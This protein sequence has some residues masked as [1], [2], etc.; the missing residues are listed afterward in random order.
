MSDK[1]QSGS[2]AVCVALLVVLIALALLR[3]RYGWDTPITDSHAWRQTQTAISAYYMVGQDFKL[4]YETPLWGAPWSAPMEFPFYQYFVAR[5]VDFT[6]FPLVSAART[7]GV[8]FFLACVI[9]LWVLLRCFSGSA[10]RSLWGVA[11]FLCSSFYSFWSRTAMIESTALF[12]S[13]TFLAAFIVAW[14]RRSWFFVTFALFMGSAAGLA[15]STTFALFVSAATIYALCDLFVS[16]RTSTSLAPTDAAR[17]LIG[18]LPLLVA[19]VAIPLAVAASWVVYSDQI[20]MQ[21][22]LATSLTSKETSAWNFGTWEQK[23]DLRV[24]RM[25][26]ARGIAALG[27][28]TPALLMLA[29]AGAAVLLS[30]RRRGE[31]LSCLGLFALGPLVFTNLYYVHDYYFNANLLFLLGALWFGWLALLESPR[32]SV[33][34]SGYAL[35]FVYLS[36][37][38][39]DFQ[40]R[41]IP[42]IRAN[43]DEENALLLRLAASVK[44]Q[45]AQDSVVIWISDKPAPVIPFYAERRALCLYPGSGDVKISKAVAAISKWQVGA[46]VNTT[47]DSESETTVLDKLHATGQWPVVIH[48]EAGRP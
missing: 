26:A 42:I 21:N 6:G 31:T 12:F 24:W 46:L 33:R 10:L 15:K 19:M 14:R 25:V 36:A 39:A 16:W 47:A 34:W 35:A 11:L 3:A 38:L 2:Q 7:V 48:S 43:P 44:Q 28:R 8:F 29:A 41:Y 32:G 4:A 17:R 22:P 13:I 5:L 20:K 45:T 23:T 9:P 40:F 30:G 1:R 18:K 27:P 37:Q